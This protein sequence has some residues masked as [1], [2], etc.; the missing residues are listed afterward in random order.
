MILIILSLQVVFC[1]LLDHFHSLQEPTGIR[2]YM[3]A[4]YLQF[5]YSCLV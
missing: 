5:H 1:P 2:K 4:T 3:E